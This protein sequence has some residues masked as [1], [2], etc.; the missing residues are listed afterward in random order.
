MDDLKI[1]ILGCGSSG[2]VPRI[3]GHWGACDPQNPKNRRQRCALLVERI[4]QSGRTQVVIDTGPDIRAQLLEHEISTLDAVLY[5][6]PHADHIHGI[7]ELRV[8]TFNKRGRLDVY[9]DAPTSDD[10]M[11][12]FGYVFEMPQGSDYPPILNLHP[13]TDAPVRIDGAGGLI[14]FLPFYARHG[15]IDALGFRMGP[16][17]YLPDANEMY[18]QG[19]AALKGVE[20]WIVD[21][22]RYTPHGS[23]AHLEQTLEWIE[24]AGVPQAY[25]TNLHIDLDYERLR[26]ETPAHVSP[27]Y[28]GLTLQASYSA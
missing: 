1:T 13:I 22:L 8:V 17:A 11:N 25:L 19:W 5:T 15:R 4:G 24:T 2:G 27:A 7:D 10:L 12:K 6:H 28:D 26:Q 9:A 18:P 21:A 3:G 14:E 20:T 16:F 23:H